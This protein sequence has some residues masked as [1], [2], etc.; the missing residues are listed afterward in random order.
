MTH[1]DWIALVTFAFV[2]YNTLVDRSKARFKA[3]ED[4]L[5]KRLEENYATIKARQDRLED[6][7]GQLA[8]VVNQ[9][10]KEFFA[11]KKQCKLIHN[12]PEDSS[13]PIPGPRLHKQSV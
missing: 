3:F 5:I 8:A 11:L 6:D 10:D 13:P 7:S 2:A 12:L 1:S 9:I 4:R